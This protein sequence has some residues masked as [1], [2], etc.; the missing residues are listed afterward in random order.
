MKSKGLKLRGTVAAVLAAGGIALSG[1]AQAWTDPANFLPGDT[2]IQFKYNDAEIVVT[3]EGQVL[4]GI[5]TISSLN[6]AAGTPIYWASGLSG[7]ELNGS[8]QNLTVASIQPISGGFK[9]FFTGGDL[10]IYNVANGSYAPTSPANAIAPQIC[11]GAC[12]A[13]WLSLNFAPGVATDDPLT[14]FNE[15]TATLVSTVNS[16]SSPLTGT[17]DGELEIIGGTA[18]STFV[19]GAGPDFS[20]QSNLQSC[21]TTNPLFSANCNAIGQWPLASF[22][23]MIGRTVPEPGS[24]ALAAIGLLGAGLAARRRRKAD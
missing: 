18:A 7:S 13:A 5:F 12:P 8:F 17:G 3:Q 2:P 23:P 20:L 21:P 24:L 4:N 1:A 22:D 9:I 6:N 15:S 16:L 14:A 10:Q 19:D 11:G